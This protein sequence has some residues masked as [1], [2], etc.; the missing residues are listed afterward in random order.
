MKIANLHAHNPAQSDALWACRSAV[1]TR[2]GLGLVS[3]VIS[4]TFRPT[5]NK[6]FCLH[7]CVL[8]YVCLW[9]KW[10]YT[11]SFYK[12]GIGSF[13]RVIVIHSVCSISIIVFS[14]LLFSVLYMLGSVQPKDSCVYSMNGMC[15]SCENMAVFTK[16][17]H[18]FHFVNMLRDLM[19]KSCFAKGCQGLA[20]C[21]W[22]LEFCVCSFEKNVQFWKTCFSNRKKL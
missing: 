11:G 1:F 20:I 2:L 8:F 9:E 12:K 13:T 5:V 22:C 15:V 18:E 14:I 16:W 7:I 21:V 10:A 6:M 19:A 17:K 4:F 3:T